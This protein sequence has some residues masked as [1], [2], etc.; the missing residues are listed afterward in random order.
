[1]LEGALEDEHGRYPRGTWVRSPPGSA[2]T[3]SSREGCMLYVKDGHLT[4]G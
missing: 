2:H 4:A 3:P 1:M